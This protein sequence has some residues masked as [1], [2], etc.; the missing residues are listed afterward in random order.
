M[1]SKKLSFEQSIDKLEKIVRLLESGDMTLSES[2]K[3]FEEGTG[4]VAA[5]TKMLDEAEQKVSVIKMGSD[6]EPVKVPF[7]D[8]I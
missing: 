3:L 4:L 7:E 8:E 6:G 1:A 5:C 2:L